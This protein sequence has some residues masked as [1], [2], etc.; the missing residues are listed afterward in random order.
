MSPQGIGT[1]LLAGAGICT[2]ILPSGSSARGRQ[3]PDHPS[4]WATLFYTKLTEV[5]LDAD[6][7]PDVL[8]SYDE[9]GRIRETV[10]NG[11][12][13]GRPVRWRTTWSRDR[14]L[15]VL[16]QYEGSRHVRRQEVEL[17]P[18]D[19]TSR[20][21]VKNFSAPRPEGGFATLTVD[22]VASALPTRA[23]YSLQPDGGWKLVK[24]EALP[25]E[26]HEVSSSFIDSYPACTGSD[27]RGRGWCYAQ[28]YASSFGVPDLNL[29]YGT[30][31]RETVDHFGV[32]EAH[33]LY[34]ASGYTVDLNSCSTPAAV[35]AIRRATTEVAPAMLQCLYALNPDM[36]SRAYSAILGQIPI[37]CG[38][39][40]RRDSYC[41]V[42]QA[43]GGCSGAGGSAA[44]TSSDGH[45]VFTLADPVSPDPAAGLYTLTSTLLHE[46]LHASSAEHGGWCD[47]HHNSHGVW[48]SPD[49]AIYGCVLACAGNSLSAYLSREQCQACLEGGSIPETQCDRLPSLAYRRLQYASEQ[50]PLCAA[51]IRAGRSSSTEISCVG[52]NQLS[53]DCE[54]RVI[55]EQGELLPRGQEAKL[56]CLDRVAAAA[57]TQLSALGTEA[58]TDGARARSLRVNPRTGV[59]ELS[60]P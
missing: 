48:G 1:L 2:A 56:S 53:L 15:R 45:I 22:E 44:A 14:S 30:E 28:A 34:L 29:Y 13:R 54:G 27:D 3:G 47:A 50:A 20:V 51:A 36:G 39:P 38:S 25:R 18:R 6:G 42:N 41:R 60:R 4:E 57:S 32:Y 26:M 7:T 49:D 52:L 33:T 19:G 37:H 24:T 40:D 31:C 16:D 23:H 5:D 17:S 9:S 21:R 43:R 55:E 58:A 11:K 8:R 10:F 12:V 46:T 59:F 35:D